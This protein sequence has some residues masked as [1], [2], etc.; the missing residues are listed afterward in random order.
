MSLT[1]AENRMGK[2][3][4]GSDS[5]PPPPW[6]GMLCMQYQLL[7]GIAWQWLAPP[8]TH[9]SSQ[10]PRCPPDDF[11]SLTR[12]HLSLNTVT[13]GFNIYFL[14]PHCHFSSGGY[15]LFSGFLWKLS[16]LVLHPVWT[17]M[18]TVARVTFLQWSLTPQWFLI[19]FRLMARF[20]SHSSAAP[21]LSSQ[22]HHSL[23]PVPSA[24]LPFACGPL[25]F[26]SPSEIL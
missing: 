26:R 22:P 3:E 8:L 12:S 13:T 14:F 21:C 24:N 6:G 20:L 11:L 5:S 15:Q 9:H 1:T 17:S 2:Y 10:E 16:F 4:G 18:S 19:F 25:S 7:R 23:L